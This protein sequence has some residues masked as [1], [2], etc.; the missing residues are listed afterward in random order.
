M[1]LDSI[2]Q[3]GNQSR[4]SLASGLEKSTGLSV[5]GSLAKEAENWNGLVQREIKTYLGKIGGR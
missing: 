5:L 4:L 2:G 1:T 3:S